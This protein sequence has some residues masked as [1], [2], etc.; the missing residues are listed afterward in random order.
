M[1]T[2]FGKY[3]TPVE[4]G[5]N[6]KL[7]FNKYGTP[8]SVAPRVPTEKKSGFFQN[9]Y[10]AIAEPVANIVARPVQV[11]QRATGNEE[12][13]GSFAGLD[14]S[15][16]ET[17]KDV[18]KDV[19]RGLQTVA[20]GIGGG[21]L[22]KVVSTGLKGKVA[23]SALLGVKE[24]AIAGSL[25]GLGSS[26]AEGKL[27]PGDILTDSATGAVIGAAGGAVL[28]GA[29]PLISAG[30]RKFSQRAVREELG[31]T[32]RKIADDY[33]RA[34]A[35]L[36]KSVAKKTDPIAVLQM[37]GKNTLPKMEKGKLKTANSREFLKTK[38][39]ELSE[40]KQE[41]LFLYN[42]R[43]DLP[44][45]RQ[46][47][48]DFAEKNNWSEDYK[49]AVKTDVNKILN[50]IE[51]A[52]TDSPKNVGGLEL[53]E[54]NIIQTNQADQSR[55][56]GGEYKPDA[57]SVIAKATGELI[58]LATGSS[59]IRDLNRL[60][61]SHYDAIDLFK[62]LSNKS[63]KG[64]KL[65]GLFM[66]LGGDVV[67]AAVGSKFG[68]PVAGAIG[69]RVIFGKI[70]DIIQNN[71]ISNPMKKVLIEKLASQSPKEVAEVIKSSEGVFKEV[72][73]E[74]GLDYKSISKTN[75]VSSKTTKNKIMDSNNITDN[76]S[77]NPNLVQRVINKFKSG[78]GNVNQEGGFIQFA[79][80][81]LTTKIL[82]D[83]EGKSGVNKQYI[84][85]A[86]NREGISK[87][88]KDLLTEVLDRFP[89]GKIAANDF[90]KAV[91]AELLPLTVNNSTVFSTVLNERGKIKIR[92][93]KDGNFESRYEEVNLPKD[94]RGDVTDYVENIYESPVKTGA[95]STHFGG[96][97]DNYFGH[98]RTEDVAGTGDRRLLEVQSD[99]FQKGGLD[100][101]KWAQEKSANFGI[102]KKP[103]AD[104]AYINFTQKENNFYPKELL[105]DSQVKSNVKKIIDK[106]YTI[107]DK[108]FF[109]NYLRAAKDLQKDIPDSIV[110]KNKIKTL[111]LLSD[112][113]S[114]IKVQ[115]NDIS[116][117]AQYENPTA[118]YRM[119]REEVKKA[120]QDGK[121]NLLL[122]KGETAMKIEGLGENTDWRRVYEIDG[123]KV[124]DKLEVGDLKVG[125]NILRDR[126]DWIITDVL[127][128][129]KF[130]AVPKNFMPDTY[131]TGDVNKTIAKKVL[132][133]PEYKK[134][135]KASTDWIED[136]AGSDKTKSA[137]RE[138]NQLVAD[139]ANKYKN[140]SELVDSSKIEQFDIS[141]KV[142][143]QNPIYKFYEKDVAKFV[144][145]NFD[146]ED[147]V[148]EN[149]VSWLKL[150]IKPE[151]AKEPVQ[152]FGA[153]L[154]NPLFIG[155]G[156][157]A[158]G[159]V[160]ANEYQ[161]RK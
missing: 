83:L 9:F 88:E 87:A 17:F 104:D 157:T 33:V 117:L 77:E 41:R 135:I 14:I 26:L 42:D 70:S 144:K 13:T 126:E 106:G 6:N 5:V 63:P 57:H 90:G 32:Y 20:F 140:K 98:A 99:L 113:L 56:F 60:I 84:R 149:G 132:S 118:H 146:V 39:G 79:P 21:A 76:V 112:E 67:G 143:K 91:E 100:A 134:Y 58:D 27:E 55:A 2:E 72:F 128:D 109:D 96:Q 53:G 45:Y 130:K 111:G 136:N 103:G 73:D 154:K 115:K 61:A 64:G 15:T 155:A 7:D 159:A 142:D 48:N 8:T 125:E 105:S 43:Y 51:N 35:I 93:S 86:L 40:I 152:A 62:V 161:K 151:Y 75:S 114:K 24:G 139:K 12:F 23:S 50:T 3:G 156:V 138:M 54:F 80:G 81:Q 22:P 150:K 160:V 78:K 47:V 65:S 148:D 38:I 74:L 127:E 97:T 68:Q 110:A 108:P 89:E 71:L 18:W 52:Y 31:D 158:A 25:E 129:G 37:Y 107:N 145:K 36:D 119:I 102:S 137:F 131:K 46:W 95:G 85:D 29:V 28:G 49:L 19:G 10:K 116:Q 59:E 11:A 153:I 30:G 66:R 133:E 4:S 120:A 147:Y 123:R 121:E 122:P 94:I 141:G 44:T 34:S 1:A 82:K 124:D 69:G 101:E 16:P 92:K